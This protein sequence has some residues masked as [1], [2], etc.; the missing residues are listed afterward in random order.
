MR[1]DHRTSAAT[2]Q[3]PHRTSINN[4]GNVFGRQP[5]KHGLI[6][7]PALARNLDQ[8]L[9]PFR[10]TFGSSTNCQPFSRSCRA[11]FNSSR[12]RLRFRRQLRRVSNSFP[13]PL[14][15]SVPHPEMLCG[16]VERDEL[17]RRVNSANSQ[18]RAYGLFRL[19][20]LADL[21]PERGPTLH[22]ACSTEHTD[23]LTSGYCFRNFF[24]CLT[25]NEFSPRKTGRGPSSRFCRLH[26]R[27]IL[28][29]SLNQPF[30]NRPSK[31]ATRSK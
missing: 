23:S 20:P 9:Y 6:L 12:N 17:E 10:H 11:S 15:R 28:N 31:S 18:R 7:P 14:T 26:L 19:N 1:P 27:Q 5:D 30:R 22:R 4:S 13:H 29:R 21:L 25:L 8:F 24:L 3:H 2:D 16:R